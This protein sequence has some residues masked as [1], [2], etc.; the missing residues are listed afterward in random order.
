[1]AQLFNVSTMESIVVYTDYIKSPLGLVEFKASEKGVTQ[2]IFCG[3]QMIDV[4]TNEIT[5]C[6]KQQLNEYFQGK[7]KAF[8]V[9]IDPQGTDF[10]KLV[11]QSLS[12]IPFGQTYTYLD[13]AKMVDR[14]KGSQ[15]VGGAN[16]R[17]PI[18]IIVPCHRVVG[19]NGSLTGYA[20]GIERK[21]WLL[22]HEGIVIKPL[23]ENDEL[24]INNVI[25]ARQ[26]KTQFLS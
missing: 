21:L 6:C 1:M 14:P 11:W 9:A 20:G 15:A 3:S 2:V 7:R 5:E 24:D 10:Q 19:T 23:K 13:I 17:N 26:S 4:K 12:K 8:D 25:H 18:S 16:G 22:E